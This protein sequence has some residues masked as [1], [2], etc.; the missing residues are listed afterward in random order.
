MKIKN[1]KVYKPIIETILSVSIIVGTIGGNVLYY[2][3]NNK[4]QVRETDIDSNN[5]FT[6]ENGKFSCYFDVGQHII[7]ISRNDAFYH[8]SEEIE[9][10]MIKEVEFNGYRDNNKITYVN[11]VPVIVT[12]TKEN[13]GQLEFNDFGTVA[14]EKNI[15]K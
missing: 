10:Y 7:T 1:L 3:Y 6:D 14:T 9:G 12:A 5:I 8:K 13:N 15:T 4:K 2:S 11:T